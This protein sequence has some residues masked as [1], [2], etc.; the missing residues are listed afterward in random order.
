MAAE[1]RLFAYRLPVGHSFFDI[2]TSE[3]FD[4]INRKD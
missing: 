4:L 1:G 3:A 2:G